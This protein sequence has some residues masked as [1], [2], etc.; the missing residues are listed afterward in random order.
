[1]WQALDDI[2]RHHAVA[3]HDLIARI[4]KG[5]APDHNLSSAI[6]VYIV[7]FYRNKATEQGRVYN[8]WSTRVGT[9]STMAAA[10]N[11]SISSLES[12]CVE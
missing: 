5:R 2:A 7:E 8:P 12:L 9:S 10:N 3:V 1:M 6:R 4:D 11:L